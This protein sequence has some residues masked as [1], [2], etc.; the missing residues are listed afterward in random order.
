MPTRRAVLATVGSLAV[1]GCATRGD[2]GPASPTATPT[3]ASNSPTDATPTGTGT[4][5]S[6][7]LRAGPIPDAFASATATVR[8][9]VVEDERDLGPCYPGVY[10]G[11]YK[12]TITPIPTPRGAC[13]AGDAVGV[14]L[15][16]TDERTVE[17]TAPPRVS[18]HALV[19]TRVVG[20][21]RNGDDL[22]AIKGTGGVKLLE[23]ASRPSG[24]YGVEMGV[25]HAPDNADYDYLVTTE[26]VDPNA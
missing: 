12:P 7:V 8:A 14:D 3:N 13:H 15:V 2:D 18:G 4:A 5:V 6:Y 22:T 16:A 11:P 9:V 19:A 1:A 17:A 23:D 26:R 25:E 20:T 21:D 10:E 24:A